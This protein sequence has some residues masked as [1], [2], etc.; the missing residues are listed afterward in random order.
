MIERLNTT[1][2]QNSALL[3]RARQLY[4]DATKRFLD[5]MVY[6]RD[7][8][9]EEYWQPLINDKKLSIGS[10]K[11]LINIWELLKNN[12]VE[13]KDTF[14]VIL[15][16]AIETHKDIVSNPENPKTH[17]QAIDGSINNVIQNLIGVCATYEYEED[18]PKDFSFDN[19]DQ[20]SGL[21]QFIKDSIM[22]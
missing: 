15:D 1:E 20:V 22:N 9:G 3:I 17:L 11:N 6:S 16:K 7:F 13:L 21:L 12:Q 2:N 8:L 19:K 5:Q 10:K 14:K 18:Y 4:G